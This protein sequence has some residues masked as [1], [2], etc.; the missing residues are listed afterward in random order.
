M[1][2]YSPHGSYTIIEEDKSGWKVD[3]LKIPYDYQKVA[4]KAKK[5]HREDWAYS[6]ITGRGLQ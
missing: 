4:E 3:H 6:L 2:N 1:E 5:H